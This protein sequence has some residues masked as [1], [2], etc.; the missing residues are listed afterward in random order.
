MNSLMVIP[1][2]ENY[3]ADKNGN[4]WSAKKKI[5]HKLKTFDRGNGYLAV[6]LSL[7]SKFKTYDVHRLIM[8]AFIGEPQ[9]EKYLV[10]HN[11]DDKKNNKFSNLKYGSSKENSKDMVIKNRQARGERHGFSKLTNDKVL[12]IRARFLKGD[13]R[14]KIAE[15]FGICKRT[16]IN[17]G[18]YKYWK[19]VKN[20]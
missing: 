4:I 1:I 2:G 20:L 7:G 6:N 12:K 19:H 10:L 17:I 18:K 16:V 3:F 9:K 11:D 14:K 8:L 5:L 15:D 13:N